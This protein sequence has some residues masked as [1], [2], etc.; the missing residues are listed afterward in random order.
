MFWKQLGTRKQAE[1]KKEGEYDKNR[2]E[3]IS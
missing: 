3:N 2:K 1:I